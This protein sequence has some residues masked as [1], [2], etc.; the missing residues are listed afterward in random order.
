MLSGVEEEEEEA[1]PAPPLIPGG[2]LLPGHDGH[3]RHRRGEAHPRLPR[4]G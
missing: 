1:T 3:R 2:Q 4:R